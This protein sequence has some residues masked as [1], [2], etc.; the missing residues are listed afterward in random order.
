MHTQQLGLTPDKAKAIEANARFHAAC[1]QRI[2]HFHTL[3]TEASPLLSDLR[4]TFGLAGDEELTQF[5]L[6]QQL[7]EVEELII[8]HFPSEESH[9]GLKEEA[10]KYTRAPP[11][12]N[13]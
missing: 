7:S 1:E 10:T 5:N 4:K 9:I 3:L 2:T 12:L 13:E 8:L 11:A 6:Q